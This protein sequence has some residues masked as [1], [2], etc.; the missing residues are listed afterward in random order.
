[1]KL[2]PNFSKVIREML[3]PEEGQ[4]KGNL[5]VFLICLAIS[6]FIW[7]LIVLSNESFTSLEYPV[8]LINPP[9]DMILVN[10]P[11][12]L[13]TFRISSAGFEL[14]T[15]RYL[16][17]K[18]PV[19]I[20]LNAITLEK[21][22]GYYSGTF[23]TSRLIAEVRDKYKFSEELIAISPE[24][25]HFRFEPL[26]GK[27][28]PVT[29]AMILNFQNQFRLSDSI[30]FEPAEV[31]VLGPARFIDSIESVSTL[32]LVVNGIGEEM[33]A[34]VGLI[35]PGEREQLTLVPD[36][37]E[38][39]I[40]GEKYTESSIELNVEVSGKGA[41]I[42]TFPEQVRVT[43]LVSLSN[44]NRIDPDLFNAVVEVPDETNETSKAKV[45]LTRVPD[46]IEV[47]RIDPQEVD[48]LVLKK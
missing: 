36:E 42:K 38:Y 23:N 19:Q 4:P 21:N 40:H 33:I 9:P 1:M 25:I 30:V 20:N 32:K 8:E 15:L 6:I 3:K 17:R 14:F 35:N 48:F 22:D 24:R 2:E 27:T 29:S 34:T 12:S 11:D 28:V 7:F 10:Q 26:T 31:K 16:T 13:V 43:Y 18:K 39:T 41:L 47:T 46:F 37:V 44:F 5:T 45:V